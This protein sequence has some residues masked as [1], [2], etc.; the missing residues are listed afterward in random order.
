MR[1]FITIALLSSF[2][3]SA[4]SSDYI[5]QG[6]QFTLYPDRIVEADQM[7]WTEDGTTI[8]S[9]HKEVLVKEKGEI[10][11]TSRA[12][13]VA[14]RGLYHKLTGLPQFNSPFP[15]INACYKM[16]LDDTMRNIKSSSG[17]FGAGSVYDLWTRDTAYSVLLG[18]IIPFPKVCLRS[19]EGNFHEYQDWDGKLLIRLEQYP[20]MTDCV[21]LI[22]AIWEY[23]LW[24]GDKGIIEKYYD[25][26]VATVEQMEREQLDPTTGLF[27]GGCSFMDNPTA[28]PAGAYGS[29]VL[30]FSNNVLYS[31]AYKTL[32][33]CARLL[34]RDHSQIRNF[35]KRAQDIANISGSQRRV[36]MLS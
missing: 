1:L 25:A 14:K 21:S 12:G 22:P 7:A 31:A 16:A 9:N 23:Y 5:Y 20:A 26:M 29:K 30:S 10:L 11:E 19:I 36:I 2:A 13:R 8:Y 32:A 3:L 4:S 15:L 17:W 27:Y 34:G 33:K 35:E 6:S 24:T 18:E 28:Y